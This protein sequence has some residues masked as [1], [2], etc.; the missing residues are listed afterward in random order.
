ME[1]IAWFSLNNSWKISLIRPFLFLER[2]FYKAKEVVVFLRRRLLNSIVTSSLVV[3]SFSKRA[4][5]RAG[6]GQ[7]PTP[8]LARRPWFLSSPTRPGPDFGWPDPARTIFWVARMARSV[9][10]YVRHCTCM[11]GTDP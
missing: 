7:S 6:S 3:V 10:H 5:L 11:T 2:K 8:N 4:K 9:R 1:F